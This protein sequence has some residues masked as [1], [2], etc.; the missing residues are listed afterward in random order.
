MALLVGSP[1]VDA[2]RNALIPV[3]TTTDQRGLPR[4]FHGTVDIGAFESSYNPQ[5]LVVD[6]PLDV[7][8]PNDGKT[9]LH[10]A[11]AFTNANGG[12]IRFDPAVF[13]AG[14]KTI[15]QLRSDPGYRD[16]LLGSDVTIIGPGADALWIL[17]G[18]A[19]GVN[20]SDIAVFPG[21]QATISGLTLA[22]ATSNNGAGVFIYP[23]GSA[24]FS[25][26]TVTANVSNFGGGIS[27][28]GTLV[29]ANCNVANNLGPSAGGGLLNNDG[30]LAILAGCTIV[31][32][33]SPSGGGI[34]NSGSLSMTD[35]SISGN[36]AT[37][38]GGGIFSS[39]P[40]RL[41]GTTISANTA[42]SGGG[43]AQQSLQGA[44]LINC[45]IANNT[46]AFTAAASR[47]SRAFLCRRQ[48]V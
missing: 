12:T 32:N 33:A 27:N 30:A 34:Y 45:T 28:Y 40:L 37:F 26:C 9:S 19:A 41:I 47:P 17:G 4:V 15:V 48:W 43:I 13:P 7:I 10:E 20:F 38:S 23:G 25:T 1:A 42:A 24:S 39:G 44:S 11:V 2:G 35:C 36:T 14:A 21:V 31:G 3:G 22:G 8:D 6:T 16:L 5:N 46:A 18:A 29:M